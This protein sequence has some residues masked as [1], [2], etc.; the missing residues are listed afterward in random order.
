MLLDSGYPTETAH[1]CL[2]EDFEL[3]FLKSV[4]AVLIR[5]CICV[6]TVAESTSQRELSSIWAMEQWRGWDHPSEVGTQLSEE[7]AGL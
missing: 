6:S 4:K 1:R 3:Y 7:M 5:P 2:T